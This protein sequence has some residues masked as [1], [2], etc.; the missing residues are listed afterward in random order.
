[1][2]TI[3]QTIKLIMIGK[4]IQNK[5]SKALVEFKLIVGQDFKQL[6]GELNSARRSFYDTLIALAMAQGVSPKKLAKNINKTKIEKYAKEFNDEAVK[7][8]KKEMAELEK[9][10]TKTMKG[11]GAKVKTPSQK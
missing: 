8:S 9:K 11:T 3:I 2:S 1:M 10:A 7:L 6:V 5:I 4:Y